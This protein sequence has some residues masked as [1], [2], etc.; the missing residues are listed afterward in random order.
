MALGPKTRRFLE[1]RRNPEGSAVTLMLRMEEAAQEI[2]KK[3][4]AESIASEKKGISEEMQAAGKRVEKQL[5]VFAQSLIADFKKTFREKI[6]SLPQLKGDPGKTPK[7]GV[8]YF[9]GE[10]G[11]P[12]YTPIQDKDYPSIATIDKKLA[13]AAQAIYSRVIK[14]GMTKQQI[15]KVI[16]AEVEKLKMDLAIDFKKIA[17]GLE[18]L[19]GNDQLSYRALKDT[20]D[21]KDG[22]RHTLHRGGGTQTYFYDLSDLCDGLTKTF[23]VP[24]NARILSVVGTDAPGGAYRPQIDWTGSGTKTLTLTSEVA[25]PTQGATLYILYVV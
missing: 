16:K 25:A 12:G 21:I 6:D 1:A 9:D 3:A 10:A 11:E 17:R 15:E 13:A 4:I 24:A 22:A 7:K 2:A 8:D 20:P 23:T 14:A 18:T 19:R 5:S